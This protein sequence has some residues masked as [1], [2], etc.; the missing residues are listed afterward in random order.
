MSSDK[1]IFLQTADRI[2][3]RL[4]R[5]AIWAGARCNWMGDSME[6]LNRTWT[7]VHRSFGPSLYNGTGGVAL[8]LLRLY[9]ITGEERFRATA[10]G[11]IEQALAAKGSLPAQAR[12][13]FY[14]GLTGIAYVLAE[15]GR[16]DEALRMLSEL[17]SDDIGLYGLDVLG[18]SAGAIAPLLLMSKKLSRPSVLELAI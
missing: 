8:F 17:G 3:A 5:D 18:G 9:S 13:G 12:I 10:Q 2:G 4:C 6:M 11:A 7:V 1:A 16:E 15:S 14:T